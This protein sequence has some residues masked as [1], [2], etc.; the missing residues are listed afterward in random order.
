MAA[1]NLSNPFVYYIDSRPHDISDEV[2]EFVRRTILGEY[3]IHLWIVIQARAYEFG[4][5]NCC[6]SDP[7]NHN[8]SHI[9]N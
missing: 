1:M 6:A 5:P 2:H 8:Q 9:I 7:R 3:L 4:V